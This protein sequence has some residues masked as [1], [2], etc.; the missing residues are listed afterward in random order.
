MRLQNLNTVR[1]RKIAGLGYHD[2]PHVGNLENDFFIAVGCS[3]TS[4][5]A[6]P[7]H[8]TWCHHLG[9]MLGMEHLNLGFPGSSLEYQYR[10]IK[11]VRKIF[12]DKMVLWMHTYPLRS[13]R[14]VLAPIIGD[15]LARIQINQTWEDS[16]SWHKIIK[17][18][19][20]GSDEK[21]LMTNCWGYNNKIKFLIRNK[22]CKKNLRYF[23]ND[24]EP[25]DTGSDNLHP[26]KD[27]HK[28]LAQDWYKHI[29]THNIK[30]G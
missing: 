11:N 1:P 14:E 27:S 25:V 12:P 17:Y 9:E 10:I 30:V 15:S 2:L 8:H 19:T 28:C 5:L 7:Y 21:V 26:G 4:G 29:T 3:F 22:I 24:E 13:H 18:V 6:L 16:E 23:L 20:L